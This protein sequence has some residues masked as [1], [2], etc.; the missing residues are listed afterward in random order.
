MK[1]PFG[2]LAALILGTFA[3]TGLAGASSPPS[4]PSD[5]VATVVS[6][7][8]ID[9]VWTDNSDNENGFGVLRCQG[10]ADCFDFGE[11]ATLIPNAT[12]YQDKELVPG[13]TYRYLVRAF[14]TDGNA[15]SNDAVATTPQIP[16]A[17]PSDLVATAGKHG[18]LNWVDLSWHDGSNNEVGF[19]VERCAGSGCADFAIIARVTM[20]S[21]RDGAVGRRTLYRYRVS[22]T[23]S[24]GDSAYSNVAE[25]ISR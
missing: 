13:I 2:L 1:I 6:P 23:N 20:P 7:T 24:A 16:P 18:Y 9:L 25:A 11:I 5:L 10:S 21:Y 12:S 8:E 22:A 19:V 4:A 14:N 3:G 15:Y 17:A